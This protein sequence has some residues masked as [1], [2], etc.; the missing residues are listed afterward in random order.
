VKHPNLA[1]LFAAWMA[2]Q[3]IGIVGE[4]NGKFRALPGDQNSMTKV[5]DKYQTTF[6]KWVTFKTPAEEKI[7]VD[8]GKNLGA[9]WT[10]T[11]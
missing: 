5:M 6:D 3:G 9:M 2:S 1:K 4:S 8:T 10:K 7:R 11:Q